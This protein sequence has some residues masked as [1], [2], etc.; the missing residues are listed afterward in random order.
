LF[1]QE[2][3]FEEMRELENHLMVDVFLALSLD[4]TRYY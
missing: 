3:N 1:S 4:G 2:L